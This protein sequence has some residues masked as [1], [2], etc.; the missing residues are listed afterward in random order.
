MS[1]SEIA[2][3]EAVQQLEV[4]TAV[5]ARACLKIGAMPPETVVKREKS[6]RSPVTA[7]DEVSEALIL[8]ELARTLPGMP[9]ISEESA[10]PSS[11]DLRSSFVIVDPLDG[12][13]EYLAGSDEFTVNLAVVSA[14]IPVIG[15]VGAPRRGLLWRGVAG[16]KAERLRL[17][18]G[19][20]ETPERIRTR[21]WPGNA[22]AIAMVS[23]SHL[24]AATDAMVA[25][26]GTVTRAP[27]GSAIKFCRV[28]EGTADVYPRLATTCEWD[29]AA[30]HALLLAAG[31]T[32]TAPDG[33]ALAYGRVEKDFRVPAF[34]AW[35]DAGK[36]AAFGR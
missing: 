15:I 11:I 8:R 5:V 33:S 25:G 35:G 17:V 2:A 3:A 26:L 7:A 19:G 21:A 27:S 32:V 18:P 12:T 36:A 10:K 34:I 13:R 6:D 23:R 16:A 31:G 4:L 20:G 24:D 22:N 29:V 1:G 28:A 30:G 9:V 14:G